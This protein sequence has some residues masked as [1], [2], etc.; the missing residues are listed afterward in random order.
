ME[1]VANLATYP[2]GGWTTRVRGVLKRD[3]EHHVRDFLVERDDEGQLQDRL[4]RDAFS[5]VTSGYGTGHAG[6]CLVS[7]I[8]TCGR[9]L[10]YRTS[11][12]VR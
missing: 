12:K 6:T 2:R 8:V 3:I 9:C 7:W 11:S 10:S 4:G 1:E 5:S